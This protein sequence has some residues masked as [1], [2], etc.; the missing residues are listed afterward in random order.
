MLTSTE[1]DNL[2]DIIV[3]V[4]GNDTSISSYKRNFN[5]HTALVVEEM[6]EESTKCNSSMRDFVS[7]LLGA[8]QLMT[9]GWLRTALR[10]GKKLVRSRELR[11]YLCLMG[12]K[13]KW[14]SAII[15]STIQPHD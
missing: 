9:R 10:T 14:K 12:V 13:S 2:L 5:S 8:G 4:T 1:Q 3:Y 6:L 7:D 15:H 11:G